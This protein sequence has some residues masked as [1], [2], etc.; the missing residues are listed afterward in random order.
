MIEGP[1][2]VRI[3]VPD[4]ALGTQWYTQAFDMEP[5]EV[6][7]D[8]V[9]FHVQGF[10]VLLVPGPAS[11]Q[12]PVVYWGVDDVASERQRLMALQ[13]YSDQALVPLNDGAEEAIVYDPFGQAFGLTSLG[14]PGIRRARNQRSAEKIALRNVRETLDS[15][16]QDEQSL[17]KTRRIVLFAGIAI[18][19]ALMVTAIV[20]IQRAKSLQSEKPL[21]IPRLERSP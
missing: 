9:T 5:S 14:D 7:P 11:P 6:R 12:S 17:R 2:A 20:A 10:A 3:S 21:T 8:G 15:L 18:V 19:I 13:T 4:L 1:R 16:Q